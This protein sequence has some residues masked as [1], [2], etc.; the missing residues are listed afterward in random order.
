MGVTSTFVIMIHEL[1]HEI[2]D[3]AHLIKYNYN[4]TRILKTQ[5]LTSFG[6]LIGGFLGNLL[7]FLKI[8]LIK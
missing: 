7:K 5:F 6:A 1:P 3:F 4:L 2:G 8:N